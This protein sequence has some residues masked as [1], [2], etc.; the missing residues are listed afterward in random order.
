MGSKSSHSRPKGGT[1]RPTLD[2]GLSD[3]GVRSIARY[4]AEP[5]AAPGATS[6]AKSGANPHHLEHRQRLRQR[7][8]TAGAERLK[9][10]SGVGEAIVAALKTVDAA[11][12]RLARGRVV[13]RPVL[14]SWEALLDYCAATM[15]R[16]QTE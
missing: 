1:A 4:G 16:A 6:G 8:L 11:A 7:F 2:S 12:H 15:A 9:E 5:V 13:N 10:V 14:S 3:A